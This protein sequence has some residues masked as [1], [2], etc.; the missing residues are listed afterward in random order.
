MV[1]NLSDVVECPLEMTS[2]LGEGSWID[3]GDVAVDVKFLVTLST[4]TGGGFAVVFKISSF[5]V[6]SEMDSNEE[7]VLPSV[8]IVLVLLSAVLETREMLSFVC[9]P[10]LGS[11]L[12][13]VFDRGA[14]DDD[15]VFVDDL[16]TLD[17][18]RVAPV[19][20]VS[21]RGEEVIC[22]GAVCSESNSIPVAV[23]SPDVGGQRLIVLY[24]FVDNCVV[25]ILPDKKIHKCYKNH[26]QIPDCNKPNIFTKQTKR[27]VYILNI[28]YI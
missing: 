15:N 25:C 13:V 16:F 2:R 21:K 9:F 27:T 19:E 11:T 4:V 12:V 17:D 10:E 24:I 5:C 23:D 3:R 7:M 1:D 8:P 20:T 22:K 28:Y 18:E 14:D 6:S 26:N